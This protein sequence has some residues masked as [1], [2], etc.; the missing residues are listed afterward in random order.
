VNAF[1]DEFWKEY[2]QVFDK[3]SQEPDVRAVVIVSSVKK[4][5]TAGIDLAA[6]GNFQGGAEDIARRARQYRDHVIEF[7]NAISAPERC[8][9]PVIVAVHGIAYGLAIDLM[10][11]CDIRYASSDALFSIKEVDVGLAADIGTL[12]RLPKITGNESAIRELAYTAR[13]FNAREAEKMGFVSRVVDGS[14]EQVSAAALEVAKLIAEKSPIAVTG[15]K[16]L[17]LHARDNSVAQN[18]EYTATWNSAMLQ[19]RDMGDALRAFKTKSKPVY[20]SLL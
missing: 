13:N 9:F 4:V 19:T 17:L 20:K 2:G 5:F 15:T 7:Q 11:A 1:N 10:A 12:A 18:L 3:I 16:R 8:P 6:L 14:K